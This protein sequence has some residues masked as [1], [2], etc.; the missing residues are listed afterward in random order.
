MAPNLLVLSRNFPNP[1]LPFLGLWVE[2][3]VRHTQKYCDLRVVSP[4]PYSPPLSKW[5]G[6]YGQYR[7][8]PQW[9]T[10][11]GIDVFHPR[12]LLGPG[13]SLHRFESQTYYRGVAQQIESLWRQTPFDLIHAHCIYPDGV[14]AV[15]L[16]QRYR[17]PVVITEH[18]LWHP[19]LD[20]YPSVRRRAVWAAKTCAAHIIASQGLKDSVARFAGQSQQMRSIPIGVDISVFTPPSSESLRQP[21]QILYVGRIKFSKGVDYLLKAMCW[22][23]KI[24]P[25]IKLR[26]VGG[27]LWGYQSPE[28]LQLRSLA[29]ELGLND[30]VEFLGAKPPAEVAAFMQSSSLLVL[31]SLRESFGA[32]LVEALAC[33]TPVVATRCGGPEDIVNES[34]GV[35]VPKQ[36]EQALAEAITHVLH[37]RH[38]YKPEHLRTYAAQRYAWERVTEQTINLYQEVLASH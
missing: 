37:H 6:H 2:G 22:L 11:H 17:V 36:N 21:H 1:I 34:V 4:V 14:V 8:V 7:S 35:L 30:S 5:L 24:Q 31:P 15:Q 33:G 16:G 19:W 26:L 18:A 12:F 23:V 13:Y 9:Q 28:E 20:E 29:Q 32:V 25:D 38:E 27:S 3:L 10:R